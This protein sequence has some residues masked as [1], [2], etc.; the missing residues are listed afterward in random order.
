MYLRQHLDGPNILL[1]LRQGGH[2]HM[3]RI[4]LVALFLI[5]A[6]GTASAQD[7]GRIT[8]TV[9]DPSGATVPGATVSALNVATNVTTTRTTDTSGLYVLVLQPGTYTISAV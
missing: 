3:K 5:A 1:E 7:S 2:G 8:G 6:A 9:T 4:L